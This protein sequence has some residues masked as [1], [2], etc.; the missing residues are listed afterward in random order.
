MAKLEPFRGDY[1]LWKYLPSIPAAAIF[2]VLFLAATLAIVWRLWKTRSWF[3]TAFAIGGLFQ[4]IGY[5]TRIVAHNNTA[6]LMPYAIQNAFILLAPVLYAASIYMTLG[7]VIRS[8][9]GEAY[10]IIRAR[11]LTRIFVT[12]DVLALMTQSGAS[13]LM[14]MDNM[15]H[16][17]EIII[18]GGLAFHIIIFGIF[19]TTAAIFHRRMLRQKQAIPQDVPWQQMLGMLYG[20]SALIMARSIFRMVEF[21]M[22]FDGYLLSTEWPLFVFDSVPMLAVMVVFWKWFPSMQ[23]GDVS[24]ASSGEPLGVMPSRGDTTTSVE[25]AW[26]PKQG[27]R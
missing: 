3:C 23:P 1:Y 7:R 24:S 9:H 26:S 15:A 13:G 8:V 20:V 5:A 27:Y 18:V 10:S 11:W 4:I 22:G 21:I 14:V 25:E 6:K 19:F 17:G 2:L 16:I 12:G